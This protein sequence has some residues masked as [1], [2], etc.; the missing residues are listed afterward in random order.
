M[1][2]IKIE[3]AN[4]IN[5]IFGDMENKNLF[6]I[7]QLQEQDANLEKQRNKLQ[8]IKHQRSEQ[9]AKMA[10]QTSEVLR[11]M[12]ESEHDIQRMKIKSEEQENFT[13]IKDQ[14]VRLASTLGMNTNKELI[15]IITEIELFLNGQL[16][17][18]D[19]LQEIL[20]DKYMPFEKAIRQEYYAKRNREK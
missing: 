8:L 2:D 6:L 13:E 14:I 3:S 19:K 17:K 5:K 16:Q 7:Q 20:Q 10:T 18:M 4:D 9:R 11:Q 12:A 15:V 1:T